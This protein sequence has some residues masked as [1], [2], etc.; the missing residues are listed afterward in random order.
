[1]KSNIAVRINQSLLVFGAEQT[2]EGAI[3]DGGQAER[4]G[5]GRTAKVVRNFPI[6]C[7][8]FLCFY[9]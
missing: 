5:A 8:G 4:P 3:Q 6:A 7:G 9:S 1:M 2:N